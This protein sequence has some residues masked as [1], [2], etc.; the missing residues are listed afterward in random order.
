MLTIIFTDGTSVFFWRMWRWRGGRV[1]G[2]TVWGSCRVQRGFGVRVERCCEAFP[3][4]FVGPLLSEG[5]TRYSLVMVFGKCSLGILL[6]VRLP[7]M[8]IGDFK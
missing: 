4:R 7:G 5:Y 6:S 3:Q 2:F 8:S 1:S